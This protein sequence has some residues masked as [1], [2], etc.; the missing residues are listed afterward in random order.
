MKEKNRQVLFVKEVREKA[1]PIFRF[2]FNTN[3]PILRQF[4]QKIN[5]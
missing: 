3:V 2:S 1:R 5:A 4:K